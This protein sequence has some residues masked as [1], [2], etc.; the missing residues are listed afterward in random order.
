LKYK[1]FDGRCNGVT[2]TNSLH[3]IH[4]SLFFEVG[5]ISLENTFLFEPIF[6]FA[7]TIL[8]AILDI[9]QNSEKKFLKRGSRFLTLKNWFL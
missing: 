8:E 1:I 5:E 7:L 2:G 4:A 6:F 9:F 3:T